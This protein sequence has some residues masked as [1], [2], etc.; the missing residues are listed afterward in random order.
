MPDGTTNRTHSE[1]ATEVGKDYPWASKSVSLGN[2]IQSTDM[3]TKGPECDLREP[4]LLD[5]SVET[6]SESD[7][8][9]PQVRETF[10][11]AEET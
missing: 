2:D 11:G 9:T 4:W 1:C 10:R 5:E 8:R 3:H 6:K 7:E